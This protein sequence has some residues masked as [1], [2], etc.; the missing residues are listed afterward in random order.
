MLKAIV[1]G[2]SVGGLCAGI[3][4]R[5]IGCDV[6]LYER[7]S[8]PMTGRGAGIVVQEQLLQLLRRHGG[9]D[10]PATSCQYRHYLQPD[11]GDG[12]RTEMALQLTSWR[13]IYQTLRG[14]F[15]GERYH[16]G[17][18]LMGFDQSAGYVLAHFAERA[19]IKTDLLICAD[20]SRSETRRRLLPNVESR[21]SGY[22]A[23]RGTVEEA[24][25]PT[26]LVRFF[27]QSFSTRLAV[28][29]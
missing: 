8:G 4:L 28:D 19:D 21:Y 13:A 12:I 29:K 5:G 18:T 10:L 17:S 22:I 9:P 23:W 7:T 15:P 14:A 1:A 6:E 25:A 26:E 11:G 27:D 2:G 20:G 3:A 16:A 24:S